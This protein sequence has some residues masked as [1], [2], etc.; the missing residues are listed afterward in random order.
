MAEV[1]I[2]I[3][4]RSYGIA[5]DDGQEQHVQQLGQFVETR[6]KQITHGSNSAN[7]VQSMVLTSLVLADELQET[8]EKLQQAAQDSNN[9]EK[10]ITY[11]GLT[12]QDE[13]N[14]TNLIGLMADK[15]ERLTART[16]DLA[17][18]RA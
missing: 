9:G 3:D 7:K 18:K 6:L 14:V 17:K 2:M 11:Q 15:V 4:G 10:I 8:R 13:Q 1:N 5:C 12:P 16:K